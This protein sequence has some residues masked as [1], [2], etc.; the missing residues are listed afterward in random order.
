MHH[1]YTRDVKYVNK[2]V[3]PIFNYVLSYRD[4]RSKDYHSDNKAII[5]QLHS[6]DWIT[7]TVADS[8][9]SFYMHRNNVCSYYYVDTLIYSADYELEARK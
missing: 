3:E 9:G 4:H 8:N 6:F 2:E 7:C 5:L 1:F